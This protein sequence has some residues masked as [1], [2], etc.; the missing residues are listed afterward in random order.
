MAFSTY[1]A[2]VTSL[3]GLTVTG[4]R[5]KQ[6]FPPVAH[7]SGDMPLMYPRWPRAE[8]GN[9]TLAG[10]RGLKQGTCELVIAI[11]PVLQG[12]NQSNYAAAI[13]LVDALETALAAAIL[14]LGIDEWSIAVEM[15]TGAEADSPEWRIVALVTASG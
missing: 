15:D 1:S 3:A 8:N 4:V 10:N 11:S 13:A 12:T 2:F 7:N 14:G 5:T 9:I 6:A